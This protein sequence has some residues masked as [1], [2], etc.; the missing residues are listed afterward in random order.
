MST[1][2]TDRHVYLHAIA[3]AVPE[4][5]YSQEFAHRF[6]RSLPAYAETHRRFLDRIYRDTGIE[7]RH[8]V[9][10]DYGKDPAEHSFYPKSA[11]LQPQPG[12]EQR[13]DTFIREANRLSQTA[14]ERLLA[15]LPDFDRRRISHLITV[16]CTGFS[17]PGFDFHL[18]K[19]LTLSPA[20]H[21]FHLGFMGCYAA[22][23][24]LKL[25]S[26]ICRSRPEARVLVVA[27]E[28][29]SLHLQ[30]KPDP[31][32]MVANALFADG[33]GAALVSAVRGDCSGSVFSLERFASRAL[34]DSEQDMAWR[35]GSVAFEMRLSAYVPR[36]IESNLG[37]ILA[38]LLREAGLD[39]RQITLWAIHPGGRAILDRAAR[40]LGLAPEELWAS[41]RVLREYGNMSSATL[42]FV[43]ELL[44]AARE[45]GKVF[46]AAFGPGLTVESAI[47]DK[48]L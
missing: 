10:G 14:V 7:K 39:R 17:A 13:N 33:A 16:S 27:L 1:E 12:V 31:E 24:A 25:A 6:L 44:L 30:L 38:D 20:L 22:L 43:L 29:C 3:T 34:P 26:D 23:P 40:T 41:Y 9:I 15:R 32:I 2:P 35:L 19:A 4:H 36:L 48:H 45:R 28:L 37:P 11:D 47:L 46:A 8:T 21:R 5:A 18:Q 42:L